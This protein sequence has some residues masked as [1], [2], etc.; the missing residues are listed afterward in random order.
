MN[1]LSACSLFVCVCVCCCLL[2][3]FV[4]VVLGGVFLVVDLFLFFSSLLVFVLFLFTSAFVF[5][6]TEENLM[7]CLVYLSVHVSAA[8]DSFLLHDMLFNAGVSLQA[9]NADL[10]AYL[11]EVTGRPLIATQVHEVG[12]YLRVKGLVAEHVCQFLLDKGF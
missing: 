3:F 8:S 12:G 4:V 1:H 9:F 11:Q 6:E 7:T 2:G 10:K 5:L